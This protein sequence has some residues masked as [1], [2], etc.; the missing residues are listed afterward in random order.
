MIN[1]INSIMYI[2]LID[3]VIVLYSQQEKQQRSPARRTPANAPLISLIFANKRIHDSK[4]WL[5][6][7]T[8]KLVF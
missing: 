8:A 4:I 7:Q 3:I 2:G 5:I 1:I 6:G